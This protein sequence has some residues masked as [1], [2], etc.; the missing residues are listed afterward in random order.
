MEKQSNRYAR[1]GALLGV[2]TAHHPLP[3]TKYLL[4]PFFIDSFGKTTCFDWRSAED[5]RMVNW[6]RAGVNTFSPSI[7]R[8]DSAVTF[9]SS[10]LAMHAS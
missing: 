1:L 9:I 7:R 4:F 10:E 3:L 8:G 5:A 2:F 6:E